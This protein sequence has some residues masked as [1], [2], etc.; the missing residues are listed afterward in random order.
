MRKL[1]QLARNASPEFLRLLRVQG[2]ELGTHRS[3]SPVFYQL[4]H[5]TAKV[6][7][8]RSIL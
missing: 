3:G 1:L 7:F 8:E 6:D 5:S 4:L 2:Q